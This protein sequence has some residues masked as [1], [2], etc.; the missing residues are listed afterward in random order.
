[1]VSLLDYSKSSW[2]SSFVLEL[3]HLRKQTTEINLSRLVLIASRY[4]FI[5]MIKNFNLCFFIDAF[6]CSLFV[7]LLEDGVIIR[8]RNAAFEKTNRLKKLLR[9]NFHA[10]IIYW[11]ATQSKGFKNI[12]FLFVLCFQV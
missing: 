6:E 12:Q 3:P 4:L 7:G 10:S 5:Y 1:M 2:V 11:V 8:I 9:Y